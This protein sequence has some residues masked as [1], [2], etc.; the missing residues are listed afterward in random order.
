MA[1]A[2]VNLTGDEA[3]KELEKELDPKELA[4]IKE[5]AERL[6][7]GDTKEQL[8]SKPEEVE[9]EASKRAEKIEKKEKVIRERSIERRKTPG[10]GMDPSQ[11]ITQKPSE[12]FGFGEPRKIK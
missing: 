6:K 12:S 11:Q 5:E 4:Q 9:K 1:Q 7:H 2:Q 3:L 8:P 10:Q